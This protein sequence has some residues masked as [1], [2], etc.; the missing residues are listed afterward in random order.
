MEQTGAGRLYTKC[1]IC[2]HF[3]GFYLLGTQLRLLDI[4]HRYRFEGSGLFDIKYLLLTEFEVRNLQY[5]PRIVCLT[6]SGTISIH[7][8]RPQI[9]EAGEKAKRVILK[10][11]LSPWLALELDLE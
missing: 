7:E 1:A 4:N 5:G 2:L 10:P 6:G 8:E 9:S 11:F 3:K